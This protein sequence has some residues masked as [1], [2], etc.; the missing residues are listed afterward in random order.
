MMKR[1]PEVICLGMSVVDVLVK[2]VGD[3]RME[4]ATYMVEDVKFLPGGDAVNEAITL[5]NLGHRVA[6]MTNVGDDEQG[7]MILGACEALGIDAGGVAVSR[8]Y[9]TATSVVLIGMNGEHGFLSRPNHASAY[10]GLEDI[11]LGLIGEGTK[12]LSIGSLFCSKLLNDSE[13]TA[14]LKKAKEAG[15]VTIADLVLDR[16]DC[17]LAEIGTALSYLDYIVPSIDEARHFSGKSE[18]SDIADAFL[19]YGVGSV[20]IKLGAKGVYAKRGAEEYRVP[21]FASRV[22]DTTGA[23]DNF[24]AGFI[25]GLVRGCAL[26]ECLRFGSGTAAISIG[27]VGATGAIHSLR[28]VQDFINKSEEGNAL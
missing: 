2:G 22:V 19:A 6:L 10:Y 3:V 21:T 25:S 1:A 4:G 13:L 12:V 14:I 11:D 24:M 26:T 5:A 28:Q 7:K 17:T 27:E 23:G 18:L 20:V 8:K 9:P 16:A 15:A